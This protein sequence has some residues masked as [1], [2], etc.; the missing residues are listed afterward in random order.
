MSLKF[1]FGLFQRRRQL[2][3]TY[4]WSDAAATVERLCKN[5]P[6]PVSDQ[7]K[8]A[9]L[10]SSKIW[11]AYP[12]KETKTYIKGTTPPL[13]PL[14]N[15]QQDYSTPFNIYLLT[16]GSLVRTDTTPEEHV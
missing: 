8:Y 12:W 13:I 16:K 1:L 5:I 9:D 14:V 10:V 6:V 11:T 3:R 2:P 15:N 4:K 7:I